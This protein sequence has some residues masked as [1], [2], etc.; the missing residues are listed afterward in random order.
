MTENVI[1][2]T[3]IAQTPFHTVP[4]LD[5][6][7]NNAVSA[8]D[9]NRIIISGLA[10]ALTP[11]RTSLSFNMILLTKSLKVATSP[12]RLMVG[13]VGVGVTG[14]VSHGLPIGSTVSTI[15][16]SFVFPGSAK[17]GVAAIVSVANA[18]SAIRMSALFMM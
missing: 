2:A 10:I 12:G 16:S 13:C 14:S 18:A 3:S 7:P 5:I 11:S 1:A 15:I 9:T 4:F 17:T 6:A 8:A